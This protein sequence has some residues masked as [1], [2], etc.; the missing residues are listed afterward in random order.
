MIK[1]VF[2]PAI[3]LVIISVCLIIS[4]CG[5]KGAAGP[6]ITFGVVGTADSLNPVFAKSFTSRE[7]TGFIFRGLL[8]Y[9]ENWKLKPVL[10]SEN[11]SQ[12]E[13]TLELMG[14]GRLQM[15]ILLR[16]NLKWADGKDLQ[17]IDFLFTFQIASNP[18]WAGKRNP[19]YNVISQIL[20]PGQGAITIRWKKGYFG[21]P[22]EFVALPKSIMERLVSRSSAAFEN[23]YLNEK[24]VGNGPYSVVD[25]NKDEIVLEANPNYT[26]VNPQIKKI[27]V[28]IFE[29]EEELLDKISKGEITAAEHLPFQFC[30][31]LKESNQNFVV[32]FTEG[33]RLWCAAINLND[34]VMKDKRVRQALFYAIDRETMA[35]EI[36]KGEG[37]AA[38]S[39]LPEQHPAFSPVLKGERKSAAEIQ[40]ILKEAGWKVGS[41]GALEKNGKHLVISIWYSKS[42][43][44]SKKIAE[45][46]RESW[47]SLNV[48][49]SLEGKDEGFLLN[50]CK[51]RD[52][53]QVA[54]Y[55][56]EIT[57]WMRVSNIF[58]KAHIPA[59][60]N[61]WKGENIT[62]WKNEDNEALCRELD[63]TFDEEPAKALLEKQQKIFAE[64]LP[65]FP[66]FFELESSVCKQNLYGWKPRGF[67]EITWNC[68]EWEWK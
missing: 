61:R 12:K 65:F 20:A 32:H 8:T 59:E 15:A 38:E 67:G 37:I 31:N 60:K 68:E 17:P 19:I 48:D 21:N 51:R 22:A 42:D 11:P 58:S 45:F 56:Y 41:L 27:T 47:A 33:S 57:P 1:K 7:V 44:F 50:A 66:L 43:P 3:V 9:D 4:S 49:L 62:G 6:A 64:E 23:S 46:L 40:N 25:Y 54:I 16:K 39:W 24:P 30:K 36:Y 14:D 34:P 18:Q 29:K 35:K 52:F 2:L 5:R 55:T 10:A 53:P 28:R 26:L 63:N 13:R